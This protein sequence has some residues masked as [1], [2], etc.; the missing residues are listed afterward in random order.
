MLVRAAL[1][2]EYLPLVRVMVLDTIQVY[3]T[4]RP[5][6]GRRFKTASIRSPSAPVRVLELPG[7]L[8]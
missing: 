4:V 2:A 1:G 8:S 5:Q 7:M 6:F 3:E